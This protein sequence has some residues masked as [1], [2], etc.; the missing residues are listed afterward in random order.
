MATMNAQAAHP[1]DP[2]VRVAAIT[3]SD[4]AT[5]PFVSRGISFATAGALT[6][7]CAGGDTNVTIPS[8]ALAAGI[9]HPIAATR[10][11]TTG[12]TAANIVIYGG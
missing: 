12:T 6:I 5:L 1:S 9:V 2:A 8:G 11:Y 3:P 4:S 7:D 10:I